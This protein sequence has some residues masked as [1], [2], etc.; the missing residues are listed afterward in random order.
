HGQMVGDVDA[1]LANKGCT[2]SQYLTSAYESTHAPLLEFVL[3]ATNKIGDLYMEAANDK[4]KDAQEKDIELPP[5]EAP[6][7]EDEDISSQLV[8]VKKDT[9]YEN[10]I[11]KLKEKTVNK[12][13]S[14]VSK[15]IAG[16]KE[17]K[18]MTFSTTPSD[19]EAA[20]ESTVA[21]GL[22]YIMKKFMESHTDAIDE[23]VQDNLMGLAIREATLNQ[24]DTVFKIPGTTF[25]EFA[26][27]I[28]MG[29]GALITESAISSFMEDGT[30][31]YEPLYKETDGQKYDVANYEKIDKDGKKTPMT[32]QE[33][34][35]ILDPDG[36]QAYQSKNK[37]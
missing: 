30:Q 26:T 1:M 35:K 4:L 12:I 32:D 16:K 36:Y 37:K 15:I 31:R 6:S 2:A 20:T 25:R 11:D 34:K 33:A 22:N 8:D 13:V 23:S 10:F 19:Q 9:E 27:R 24:M 29:H 3:R 5:P 18:D 21:V 7:V 14:D 17:E 28:R